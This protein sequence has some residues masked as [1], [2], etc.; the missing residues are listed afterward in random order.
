MKTSTESQEKIQINIKLYWSCFKCCLIKN[1]CR[2]KLSPREKTLRKKKE[3]SQ[4]KVQVLKCPLQTKV[5]LEIAS[6]GY[7]NGL[8]SHSLYIHIG[9]P[10]GGQREPQLF[11]LRYRAAC[12]LDATTSASCGRRVRAPGFFYSAR[13]LHDICGPNR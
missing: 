1:L 13:S 2:E 12:P 7:I 9:E 3:Y 10:N 5:Q 8:H 11:C 4:L 6:K